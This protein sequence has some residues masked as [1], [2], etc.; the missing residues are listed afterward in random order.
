M[1]LSFIIFTMLCYFSLQGQQTQLYDLQIQ[2]PLSLEQCLSKL[3][4]VYQVEFSYPS[5]LSEKELNPG[6]LRSCTELSAYLNQLLLPEGIE[7]QNLSDEQIL[8]RS[9]DISNSLP[10][11]HRSLSGRI[12]DDYSGEG[13]PYSLVT[14]NEQEAYA[15]ADEEG[16]FRILIPGTKEGKLK[17]HAL[18][19]LDIEFQSR[20]W[21]NESQVKLAIN[22]DYFSEITVL[23]TK[24]SLVLSGGDFDTR[25]RSNADELL[26]LGGVF[27][28]DVFRELQLLA[29][30]Q[31]S[32]DF[33]AEIK[34]RGS[35]G[36]ATLILVDEI[37]IY[38]AEHYY[39]IFSSINSDYIDEVRLYKNNMPIEYGGKTGGMVKMDSDPKLRKFSGQINAS[40]LESSAAVDVP[41][42]SYA[43]ISLGARV[44]YVDLTKNKLYDLS[45]QN[46]EEEILKRGVSRKRLITSDPKF[47]Y[48][49]GNGKFYIDRGPHKF[50]LNAFLSGDDFQN[51]YENNYRI[52]RLSDIPFA[53]EQF[54]HGTNWENKGGSAAYDL[55]FKTWSVGLSGFLTKFMVADS[56][57]TSFT[58]D[59]M[60]NPINNSFE[61][62][63]RN[64]VLGKGLKLIAEKEF[65]KINLLV[66][67][68]RIDHETTFEVF[69]NDREDIQKQREAT[70]TSF[71]ANTKYEPFK[72]LKGNIGLR[73][74]QYSYNH[75]DKWVA[76]PQLDL[77]YYLKPHFSLKASAGRQYQFVR[78]IVFE[79][80]FG[81]SKNYFLLVN[82]NIPIGF[83]NK[84]M[85]GLN[86]VQEHFSFDVEFFFK[87]LEGVLEY[88]TTRVGFREKDLGPNPINDY[89]IFQGTGKV[90]GVDIGV[91]YQKGPWANI[92]AYTLSESTNQ[93]PEI[94]KNAIFPSR[95]D[96]RH[97][98]Q[99]L[100][101]YTWKDFSFFGTYV[102]ASGRPY[103]DLSKILSETDRMDL[104]ADDV[105]SRLPDYHRV[106][107]GL[108][109]NFSIGTTRASIGASVFNLFDRGNV[110]Y[111]QYIYALPGQSTSQG[112]QNEV[113]GTETNQLDRTFSVNFSLSF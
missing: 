98:L 53:S 109:Y 72:K 43:G 91:N 111:L 54:D 28:N 17:F 46:T 84:F 100:S 51:N 56:V 97:Q 9:K 33:S 112:L 29:G 41:I 82:K 47:N 35:G 64:T 92:L 40:L 68:Q 75:T 50:Q 108:D 87:D 110:K 7:F 77:S 30:I 31:A 37:P 61:I 34:I 8:L 105:I 12:V 63:T 39:G 45:G 113:L 4:Q 103:T 104:E 5:T 93:F 78:E 88:G 70:E 58:L 10:A 74:T 107:V 55:E 42:G 81:Q 65:G 52:S 18:G 27:S 66:G 80:R 2:G 62:N 59:R 25:I 102:F 57:L 106:D 26:N 24:P 85:A 16:N 48:W 6:P 101:K 86:F 76:S 67:I 96:S 13:I 36:D 15:Y 14:Y 3:K 99:L 89:K 20:N 73:A 38:K 1:R 79:N 71:F 94:Y 11:K 19:Y 60:I 90:K 44:S 83:S 23:S 32:D 49:D 69:N 21:K 22:E 95:E